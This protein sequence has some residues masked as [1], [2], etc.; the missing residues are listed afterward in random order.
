MSL[1]PAG[2]IGVSVVAT[3]HQQVH[4]GASEQQHVWDGAQDMSAV[5]F[6]KEEQRDGAEQTGTEPDRQ[7]ERFACGSHGFLR[8][9]GTPSDS[10]RNG[11]GARRS[12]TKPRVT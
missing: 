8:F 2:A 4:E 1:V 10:R 7:A 11:L 5:L 9:Q 6:P 12:I 3:M